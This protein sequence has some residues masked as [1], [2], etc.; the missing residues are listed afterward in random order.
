MPSTPRRVLYLGIDPPP[1]VFHYPVIRTQKIESSELQTALALFFTHILFTSK[2]AV[3]YWPGDL[4]GAV[5]IAIGDATAK[6]IRKRGAEP[7]VASEATQE[8]VIAFLETLDLRRAFLLY[9]RSKIARPH[10]AKYLQNAKIAHFVFDLYET[11]FQRPEPTPDLAEFDEIVFTAPSAVEGF[12]RIFRSL[13][14]RILLTPIGPVTKRALAEY[15]SPAISSSSYNA[16]FIQEMN[17][18]GGSRKTQLPNPRPPL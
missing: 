10:L 5:S 7:L 4:S 6:E 17:D 15:F 8:G 9:P 3:R 2:N 16:N 18:D 14:E 11:L 13:P 1:G 12:F